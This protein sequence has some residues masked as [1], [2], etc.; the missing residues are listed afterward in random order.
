MNS[1][2]FRFIHFLSSEVSFHD[3]TYSIISRLSSIT[4]PSVN[5]RTGTV[6][7]GEISIIWSGLSRNMTSLCSTSKPLRIIAILALIAYGHLRKEYRIGNFMDSNSFQN[8]SSSSS[9]TSKRS[10]LS[11]SVFF[12]VSFAAGFSA[13]VGASALSFS[14]SL[15]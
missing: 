5:C 15:G 4:L 9:S 6:P 8:K 7:F 1:L 10:S 13:F 14:S 12:A 11:S 3:L 2:S